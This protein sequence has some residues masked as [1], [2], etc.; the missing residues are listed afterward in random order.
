MIRNAWHISGG[1]G[2]AAN[3]SNLR[4]MVTASDGSERVVAL[5]NDLGLKQGDVEGIVCILQRQGVTDIVKIYG[6]PIKASAKSS[7]IS[8]SSS[9]Q[10]A[11]TARH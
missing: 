4:V 5:E 11:A 7:G 3:S 2:A 6:K 8:S 9:G 1:E 10:A